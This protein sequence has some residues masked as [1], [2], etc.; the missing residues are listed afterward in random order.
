MKKIFLFT[1]IISL[2]IYSCNKNEQV[3]QLTDKK[4]GFTEPKNHDEIDA[5]V[6]SFV[7]SLNRTERSFLDGPSS[8]ST[9]EAVWLIEAVLNY[10]YDEL[11][12][13]V[14]S[15][16][17]FKDSILIDMNFEE[18]IASED[19]ESIF[20]Q[21]SNSIQSIKD[22][23]SSNVIRVVDI[24]LKNNYMVMEFIYGQFEEGIRGI[25]DP[26]FLTGES[27][28]AYDL[29]S[30]TWTSGNPNPLPPGPDNAAKAVQSKLRLRYDILYLPA[31]SYWTSV[32]IWQP[33][34]IGGFIGITTDY[35]GQSCSGG[36]TLKLWGSPGLE[37]CYKGTSET[38]MLGHTY[39]NFVLNE[40]DN[41]IS[42]TPGPTGKRV[43]HIEFKVYHWGQLQNTDNTTQCLGQWEYSSSFRWKY[44]ILVTDR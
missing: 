12:K 36:P 5:R 29:I 33:Q 23:D 20:N 19:C 25:N 10:S 11:D 8:Y 22:A 16:L 43:S 30:Y 37:A 17:V 31:F 9:E 40:A 21:F 24:E 18:N 15:D 28:Y 3:E 7:R 35:Y 13:N 39:L 4:E 44:G 38:N 27:Y 34:S 6:K 42:Y 26:N 2:G 1:L 41:R 32:T 14:N